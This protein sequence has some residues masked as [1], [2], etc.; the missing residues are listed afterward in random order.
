M[1]RIVVRQERQLHQPAMDHQEYQ[2]VDCPMPDVVELLLLDRPR[3]R[4]TDRVTLQDLE[5]RDLIDTYHPDALFGKPSRVGIAPKDLLR[6][7]LEPGIQ[8]SRLPVAGATGLQI[9]NAQ[10]ISHSPWADVSNDPVR[11][12]LVGQIIT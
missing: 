10:N 11:H 7:L 3:N 1:L 8:S 9:N 5:G 4:S 2:H 6:P 12:G